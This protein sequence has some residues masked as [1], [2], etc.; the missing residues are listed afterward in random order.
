SSP[1]EA[2]CSSD[3]CCSGVPARPLF[4]ALA[5]I[6][7]R[8]AS[9]GPRWLA[10]GVELL[11]RDRH[12]PAVLTHF[13]QVE[14][15]R[16]ILEHPML[17]IELGGDALN[18]A[19]DPERLIAA[20]ATERFLLFEHAGGGSRGAEIELRRKRGDLLRTICFAQS[21]LHARIFRTA[22]HRPLAVVATRPGRAGRHAGEA[23]RTAIDIDLDRAEGR[24]RGQPDNVDRS[25][26]RALQFAQ[27]EAHDVALASR[28]QEGRWTPRAF[29][30]FDRLQRI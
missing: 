16:G 17:A 20:D 29:T 21:A 11:L 25:G 4:L 22:Q 5:Q 26:R 8:R 13:D 27:C 1:A 2:E 12:N 24:T 3:L 23:E 18:R 28:G 15:L 6:I 14:A 19:L 7:L 10:I 9:L 30:L